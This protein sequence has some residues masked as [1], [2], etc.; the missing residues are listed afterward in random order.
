MQTER[1]KIQ[2]K[3]QRWIP[4]KV[5]MVKEI[6]SIKTYEIQILESTVPL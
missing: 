6:L 3:I 4:K 1:V 5:L 2:E